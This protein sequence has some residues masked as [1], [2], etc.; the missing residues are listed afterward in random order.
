MY[1]E[2]W[3]ENTCTRLDD[4]GTTESLSSSLS[5]PKDKGEVLDHV[6]VQR[7]SRV[8]MKTSGSWSGSQD[9]SKGSSS[10]GSYGHKGDTV[11]GAT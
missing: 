4:K 9:H 10:A 7:C 8:V 5:E 3:N 2:S 11:A 1:V 6:A